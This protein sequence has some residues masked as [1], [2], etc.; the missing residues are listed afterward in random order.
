MTTHWSRRLRPGQERGLA[1]PPVVIVT[2][3]RIPLPG[4]TRR[5]PCGRSRRAARTSRPRAAQ[6][7]AEGRRERAASR[8]Q[9]APPARGVPLERIL[10]ARTPAPA[11]SLLARLLARNLTRLAAASPAGTRFAVHL[12][13]GTRTTGPGQ[14]P[15]CDASGGTGQR[16]RRALATSEPPGPATRT[17]RG[18]R[19][20]REH[21]SRLP[22]VVGPLRLPAGVAFAA[23]LAHEA[24]PLRD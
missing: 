13:G 24:K 18:R 20:P 21:R 3:W 23:G 8:A 10:L 19:P 1:G 12:C 7:K 2:Q 22:D 11:R 14:T 6:G 9:G 15:R 17:L 16:D 5:R 4:R